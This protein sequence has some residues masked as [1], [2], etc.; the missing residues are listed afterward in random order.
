MNDAACGRRH[1]E[2]VEEGDVLA[3]QVVDEVGV[4]I[5]QCVDTIF[6]WSNAEDREPAIGI[7][8]AST[9]HRHLH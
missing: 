8:A 5:G 2:R 1:D 9:L 4:A 6:A 7:G 3:I